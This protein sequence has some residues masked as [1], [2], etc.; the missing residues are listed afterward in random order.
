MK[1][2][3]RSTV[4]NKNTLMEQQDKRERG[5]RPKSP[6][7]RSGLLLGCLETAHDPYLVASDFGW[8]RRRKSGQSMCNG[9]HNPWNY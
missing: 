4:L 7:L 1:S 3:H 6:P 5:C 8:I 2:S 9:P